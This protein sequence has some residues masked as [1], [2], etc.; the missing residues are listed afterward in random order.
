MKIWRGRKGQTIND[1]LLKETPPVERSRKT[2][3]D[4]NHTNVTPL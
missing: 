2:R 3:Q 1:E 4:K